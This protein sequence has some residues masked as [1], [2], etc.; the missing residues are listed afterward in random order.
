MNIP[1][2]I[3]L[4]PDRHKPMLAGHPW[5]FSGAILRIEKTNVEEGKSGDL[6][7]LFSC[8]GEKLGVGYH[9]PKSSISV[10]VL[11]LGKNPFTEKDFLNR[12]EIAISR[13]TSYQDDQNDSCRLINSEGDFLPGL[14]VDQFGSGICLQISTKG[15]DRWRAL[16]LDFLKQHLSPTF[17]FEKSLSEAMDQESLNRKN[18]LLYGK[19]PENFQIRE[20][21]L[22]F[23]ILFEESQKTGFFLDQRWNRKLL[24]QYARDRLVLDCFCYTGGFSLSAL[25]A[26]AKTVY[27][28]D[29]SEKAIALAKQNRTDNGFSANP[30]ECVVADAFLYLREMTAPYDLIVLDP[31]KFAKHA[32]QVEK[33]AHGY[34]DINWLAFKKIKKGGILFTHSCSQP[35]DPKLFRQIVFSAAADAKRS[36]QVLHV[37]SHGPDHPVNLAHK[38]GEYL[39]GLVLR[40]D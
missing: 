13:R 36:V 15:M 31:P 25:K 5:I 22:T 24:M 14:I 34:K 2:H 30:A 23:K 40:V 1:L 6:C 39:K 3:F 21:G 32:T 27:S 26:G 20:N 33:A 8:D 7:E 28:V 12:L 9:N 38:E 11:Q 35:I 4:K 16:I 18:A 19:V 37:L 10:R 29:I 17:I